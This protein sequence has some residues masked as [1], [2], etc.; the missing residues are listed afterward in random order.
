MMR[1]MAGPFDYR[2]FWGTVFSPSG[3]WDAEW[4]QRRDIN[5]LNSA[6][7]TMAFEMSSTLESLAQLREHVFLISVTVGVMADMLREAGQ[8]DPDV[9]RARVEA[10]LDEARTPPERPAGPPLDA[11]APNHAPASG[12]ATCAKCGKTVLAAQTTITERGTM[13]DACAGA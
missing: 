13:C 4:K 1:V 5:E 3:V 7:Q 8:L 11:P 2:G 9:L 10:R 12:T 6:N